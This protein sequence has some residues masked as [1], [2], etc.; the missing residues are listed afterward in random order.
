[1]RLMWSLTSLWRHLNEPGDQVEKDSN[2][3]EIGEFEELILLE[4][5]SYL[6][7]LWRHW[8][9]HCMLCRWRSNFGRDHGWWWQ[10][11][12]ATRRHGGRRR[13]RHTHATALV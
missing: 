3:F 5:V 8:L 1:M 7:Y 4:R 12:L 10:R 13:W 2:Q 11:R 9:K 6:S